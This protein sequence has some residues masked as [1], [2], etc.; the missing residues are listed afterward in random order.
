MLD[1]QQTLAVY[2]DVLEISEQMLEAALRGDADSLYS[3]QQQCAQHVEYLRL[4]GAATGTNNEER[5]HKILLLQQILANDKAIR[6][7]AN[8]W[9][10]ELSKLLHTTD[11]QLKINRHY[12][13]PF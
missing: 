12:Q 13:T 7:I 10:K 11:N 4:E 6:D 1:H 3:L 2:Q 5:E 8:P 9:L